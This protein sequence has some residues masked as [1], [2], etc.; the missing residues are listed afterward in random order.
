MIFPAL[1]A[2]RGDQLGQ[3]AHAAVSQ[4]DLSQGTGGAA[5]PRNIYSGQD[6]LRSSCQPQSPVPTAM[7]IRSRC[8]QCAVRTRSLCSTV[9][10]TAARDLER[11]VHR[12]RIREGRVIYGGDQ[13]S[14]TMSIIISGVIKIINTRPDGRHQIVGLQF[15]SEF[16]GRPFAE[17]SA[18]SA[19]AATDLEL[20]AFSGRAFEGVLAKHPVLERA[21]L[22]RTLQDL[23]SARDWMFLLGL[24]TAEEK[25]AGFLSMIVERLSEPDVSLGARDAGQPLRLPLS[26]TEIAE[27]LSLRLETVSRQFAQL[28]ARRIIETSGRRMFI[29]RDI[30]TLRRYPEFADAAE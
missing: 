25:V 10:E 2:D 12:I 27:C 16:V 15:P 13:R 23:D 6:R 7:N 3:I 8:H 11:I 1:A 30:E 29:I 19:E 22:R 9:G 26:R 28:K 21:L 14:N 18:I 20:C 24:K 4:T 5:T 17:N